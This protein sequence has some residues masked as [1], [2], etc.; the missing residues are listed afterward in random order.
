MLDWRDDFN[1]LDGS[2]W[3]VSN[4]EG[5]D[6]NLA[7]YMTTQVSVDSGNLVLTLDKTQSNSPW[8]PITN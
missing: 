8:Y 7:T 5:F 6:Q 2:K 4:N 3:N 1:S